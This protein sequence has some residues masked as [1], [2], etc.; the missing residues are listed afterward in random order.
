[1]L[2][3]LFPGQGSQCVGMGG[4]LFEKFP[5]LTAKADAILGYSIQ[6]LCLG[7]TPARF[8]QTQYTQPALY[9]VNALT[10][11]NILQKS[12]Q[13]PSYLAG[14]SLG[15]Y[16]AL[17]AADVFDFES[18]LRLVQK[19]GELMGTVTGGGMAAIIGLHVDAIKEILTQHRLAQISIAN[20]N[21]H[22]QTVISG[23]KEEIHQA[24]ALC[25]QYQGAMVI[26]LPVSGAFH[27]QFMRSAQEQFKIFIKD[28]IF[29][30]PSIPVI[31]NITARPYQE[32]AIHQMM[33]EQ[34]TSSVRWTET[35]EY[36]LAQGISEFKEIGPGRVL[37]GLVRRIKN[38]Q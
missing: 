7:E 21:S 30:K 2:A 25:E 8:N 1:M 34:I 29:S 10:Y 24:Q 31:A 38:G 16:N 22:T 5:D 26:P 12:G 28:F 17:L 23:K 33:T 37:N 32:H 18:G 13:K 15:E 20:Y 4:D 11:F 14:H 6:S 3:Y 27:S 36:L 9:T 19:R 35:I